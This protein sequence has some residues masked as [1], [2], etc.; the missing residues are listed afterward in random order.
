MSTIERLGVKGILLEPRKAALTPPKE[1]ITTWN[2]LKRSSK[3]Y[4][5]ECTIF[6][7]PSKKGN[8]PMARYV[9]GHHKKKERN[10]LDF[11]EMGHFG[12]TEK[13]V[14]LG[15]VV[16]TRWPTV[17]FIKKKL[18]GKESS[19]GSSM[20]R[21]Q[22]MRPLGV[23]SQKFKRSLERGEKRKRVSPPK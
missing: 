9:P 8:K 5:R 3:H 13:K 4:S 21:R 2:V 10:H 6:P 22:P 23:S 12:L 16:L 19:G 14:S 18:N 15:G 17:R 7:E 20:M 11:R 1:K